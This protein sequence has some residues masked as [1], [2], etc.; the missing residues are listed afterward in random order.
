MVI[1]SAWPVIIGIVCSRHIPGY[2]MTQPPVNDSGNIASSIRLSHSYQVT[3]LTIT[4]LSPIYRRSVGRIVQQRLYGFTPVQLQSPSA[5]PPSV[6]GG[7]KAPEARRPRSVLFA[8][9]PSV[10]ACQCASVSLSARAT[11]PC[12][13]CR[14]TDQPTIV[15]SCA[16]HLSD[17]DPSGR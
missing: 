13:R 17:S 3:P 1:S 12:R 7:R 16:G 2:L 5:R 10:C 11:R 14:L 6:P 15:R 9:C 8:D 4:S